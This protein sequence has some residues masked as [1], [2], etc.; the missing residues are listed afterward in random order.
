MKFRLV[1]LVLLAAVTRLPA[2]EVPAWVS[3]APALTDPAIV[4]DSSAAYRVADQFITVNPDGIVETEYRYAMDIRRNTGN[5]HANDIEWYNAK[6]DSVIVADAW[7]IRDGKVFEQ[8]GKS[9]WVDAISL[10]AFSAFDEIRT[11]GCNF[12]DK[13]VI[14]DIVAFRVV[15]RRKDVLADLLFSYGADSVPVPAQTIRV[16]LPAGW[17]VAQSTTPDMPSPTYV[18]N[19][20][21]HTWTLAPMAFSPH[22]SEGFRVGH[23]LAVRPKG[24]NQTLRSFASWEEMGQF[25]NNLLQGQSTCPPALRQKAIDLTKNAE[26]PIAKIDALAR[27]AQAVR[28]VSIN[29][30]LSIGHGMRPRS[31]AD[32]A[33]TGY[34]DCK[35]K[36]NYLRALLSEVGIESFPLYLH[37]ERSAAL[38]EAT[39]SPRWFNHAIIAIALPEA[40]DRF[41]AASFED[42]GT[43][44]VVFDPTDAYTRL[45]DL[46]RNIQGNRAFLNTKSGG[47]LVQ[48]PELPA[49]VSFRSE[50]TARLAVN[51]AGAATGESRIVKSGQL[52][53]LA[54]SYFDESAT[55]ERLEKFTRIHLGER[56][57]SAALANAKRADSPEDGRYT[58]E[59]SATLPQYLQFLP[60]GK[61][62]ARFD[63]FAKQ[64]FPVL[65]EA[66]RKDP[67][68]LEPLSISDSLTIDLQGLYDVLELPKNADLNSPYGTFRQVVAKTDS[69]LVVTREYEQKRC[70]VPPADYAKLKQ[71]LSAVFKADRTSAV[72]AVKPV[73]PVP[74]SAPAPAG[75]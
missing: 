75:T 13:A 9:K 20:R 19:G 22:E 59:F 17:E 43:R 39:P 33:A 1:F 31:A 36:V 28:Y 68:Y 57:Q 2:E 74:A 49:A 72:L 24:P 26:D 12:S 48:I 38:D 7:L 42:G 41:T 40:S 18:S 55:A 67:V 30:N 3:A 47:H 56:Y 10:S 50:R 51:A 44:Y 58:L 14:N 29:R 34:G 46:P 53:T 15:V 21:I 62:I 8:R 23:A 60:G 61:V 54:R 6:T 66:T 64:N 11:I 27:H 4:G 65:S 73:A 35:D 37:T 5:S 32:V 25:V 70:L 45:G 69:G 71:F 52:A 63:L 16:T